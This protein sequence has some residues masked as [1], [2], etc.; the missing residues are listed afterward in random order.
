MK[1][2]PDKVKMPPPTKSQWPKPIRYRLVQ[3]PAL[4]EFAVEA[5]LTSS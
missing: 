1:P 2:A 3:L 4:V 5:R